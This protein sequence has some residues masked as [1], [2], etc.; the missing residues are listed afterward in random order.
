MRDPI[1]DMIAKRKQG[2]HC[3]IPSF[4]TANGIVIEAI[5]EQARRFDDYVLIEATA[6]QVNQYGGYTNM[7]PG[8]FKEFVCKIADRLGFPR[9]K[10]IFGGDHLGPLTWADEPEEEAMKKA[11]ELVRLFVTAG[12][13]KIHLDTSMKLASDSEQLPLPDAVIA[14]RG[15]VLYR[16]CEEEY[17]KLLMK[18]A[19][20]VRPV[21]IIG[22][23][24]PIPGGA[25]SE[26]VIEVTR[27]E[28]VRQT[29]DA[30]RREFEAAGQKSAFENIIG[31]VVQP[32]V[33][34]GD[35]SICHYDRYKAAS[36]CEV[37]KEYEGLVYE[38]H[39]TDYQSPEEL[40]QMVEDGIAI[41]KVGP[42]LTFALR[43]ALFALSMMEKELVEE[44][45]ADFIEVLEAAMNEDPQYWKKHYHGSSQ[46]VAVKCKYSF[47]D[48]CRYYFSRPKTEE[49]MKKL[50]DNLEGVEIPLSMIAQYMPL[51]YYKIRGGKLKKDARTMAK[52]HIINLVESYNY[53]VKSNYIIGEIFTG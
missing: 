30:Y 52:D 27:P 7:L 33:E 15:A 20:E 41:L 26:E 46:E 31:L 38:G 2:I 4:C 17:Q 9:E 18:N 19:D 42:A 5:L 24:V 37:I 13:K 14:R 45:R 50:F 6:N 48:R 34:F 53:A 12:Y 36:L 43:E 47:S 16:A 8:D 40:R 28:A 51:Q 35:S 44:N 3:G 29:M 23:E 39:S 32:G 25:R 21:F 1:R 49:A 10:L 22:S 11:E